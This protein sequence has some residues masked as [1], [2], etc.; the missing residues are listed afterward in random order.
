MFA[1]FLTGTRHQNTCIFC[2]CDHSR[3]PDSQGN[4]SACKSHIGTEGNPKTLKDFG[5]IA[6]EDE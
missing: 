4:S 3:F 1:I 2:D 6:Q 5:R